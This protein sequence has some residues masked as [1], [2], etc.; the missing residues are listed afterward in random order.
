M[1]NERDSL[2]SRHKVTL[3]GDDMPLNSILSVFNRSIV[4]LSES[5]SLL[6]FMCVYLSRCLS[7]SMCV[8]LSLLAYVCVCQSVTLPQSFRARVCV[9][10]CLSQSVHVCLSPYQ[11]QF[12]LVF[13]AVYSCPFHCQS[14]HV[15]VWGGSLCNFIAVFLRLPICFFI[16]HYPYLW[17]V[18]WV[19][20]WSISTF[21]GYLIPN[22]L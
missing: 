7:C 22:P 4:F 19:G 8:P 10:V 3:D 9:C 11:N 1:Y 18:G 5:P 14:A 6:Q 21:V 17:M 12:K 13:T 2:T 16:Q 20:F 15:C